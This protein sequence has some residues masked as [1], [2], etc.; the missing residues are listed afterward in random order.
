M[1]K[2]RHE[3]GKA[4]DD[5]YSELSTGRSTCK[6]LTCSWWKNALYSNWDDVFRWHKMSSWSTC[7]VKDVL[8]LTWHIMPYLL[9]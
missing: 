7:N 1:H 8:H 4:R 9:C 3:T 5:W 2:D 6:R